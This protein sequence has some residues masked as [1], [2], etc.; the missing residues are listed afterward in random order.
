MKTTP[1]VLTCLWW[2]FALAGSTT[3]QTPVL[4]APVVRPPVVAE[5]VVTE[6]V[7]PVTVT[8]RPVV[9]EAV[10]PPAGTLTW[11]DAFGKMSYGFY[12]DGFT[13]DNWFYDYYEMP[14]ATVAVE[15]PAVERA[16]SRTT[17]R[18]DPLVEHRLFRW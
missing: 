11:W 10:I 13:D 15:Q 1:L 2:L 7:P 3:A 4:P 8:A 17:W 16:G 18:Y 12:D 9:R 5:T 6:R 14:P